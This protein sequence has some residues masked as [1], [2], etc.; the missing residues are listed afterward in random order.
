MANEGTLLV[1]QTYNIAF[2]TTIFP[3]ERHRVQLSAY[4]LFLACTGARAAEIVDNKKRIPKDGSYQE[5]WGPR[6]I[7]VHQENDRVGFDSA[8]VDIP[9]EKCKEIGLLCENGDGEPPDEGSTL[10]EILSRRR[11]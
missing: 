10:L 7:G 8:Y 3:L 5:L 4:Y 2:D 1:L 9:T 11:P 6:G